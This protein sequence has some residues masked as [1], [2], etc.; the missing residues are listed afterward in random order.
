MLRQ[1]N[2]PREPF[3]PAVATP[4]ILETKVSV[5]RASEQELHILRRE[6][7]HTRLIVVDGAIDHVRLLLLQHD[8]TRLHRVFDA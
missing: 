8:H 4:A 6:L 1:E 7:L 2:P 5:L 3:F